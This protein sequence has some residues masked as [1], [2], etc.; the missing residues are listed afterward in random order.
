MGSRTHLT[1]FAIGF[2]LVP[3]YLRVYNDSKLKYSARVNYDVACPMNFKKYPLDTQH[4]NISFEP[5]GHPSEVS[6]LI[7]NT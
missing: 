5:W 4:C 7:T 6:F 3:A 2:Q 1:S